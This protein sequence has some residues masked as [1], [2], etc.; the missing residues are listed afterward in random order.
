MEIQLQ[1]YADSVDHHPF[2]DVKNL[3]E[4]L[5]ADPWPHRVHP[6]TENNADCLARK[7]AYHERPVRSEPNGCGNRDRE[8][9]DP[10][11]KT[12]AK[13]GAELHVFLEVDYAYVLKP[14]EQQRK[15]E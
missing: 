10:A 6:V 8:S 7:R 12:E 4:F 11:Q 2:G 15:G 5:E 13:I 1:I 14:R 9:N 3:T